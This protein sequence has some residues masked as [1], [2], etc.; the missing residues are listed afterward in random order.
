M[1][2]CMCNYPRPQVTDIALLSPIQ[3]FRCCQWLQATLETQQDNQALVQG[4]PEVLNWQVRGT[5]LPRI[6]PSASPSKRHKRK[7]PQNRGSNDVG[8]VLEMTTDKEA[9]LQE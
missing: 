2:V 6:S 5:S 1:L 8:F 4:V 3:Q 7:A 9:V